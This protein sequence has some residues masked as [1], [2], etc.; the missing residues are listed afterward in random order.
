MSAPQKRSIEHP[1]SK[2]VD[3]IRK[4]YPV[5]FADEFMLNESNYMNSACFD[6][7]LMTMRNKLLNSALK[8]G[9]PAKGGK[10]APKEPIEDLTTFRPFNVRETNW[11][12]WDIK[13][14]KNEQILLMNAQSGLFG[15]QWK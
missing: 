15:N 12:V 5:L 4:I 3:T 13:E 14:S 9:V 8:H 11:E 1:M 6:M 7:N 10:P 2:A